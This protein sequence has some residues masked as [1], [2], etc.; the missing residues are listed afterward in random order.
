MIWPFVE[1]SW[2]AAVSLMA[3]TP[4]PDQSSTDGSKDTWVEMKK[5]QDMA[6]LFGKTLYHQ[7]DLSYYEAVNKE[8]LTR[9]YE[10]F[11]EEGKIT[12]TKSKEPNAPVRMQLS[13]E[14][15][16]ERDEQG[17]IKP[18]GKL[19]DFTEMMYVVRCASLNP[20]Q[21]MTLTERNQGERE[22]TGEIMLLYRPGY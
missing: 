14:W 13:Q 8:V 17:N 18:E 9:S 3:L 15:M 6:Q 10:R 1:A 19:W 16:P 4:P 21:L 5:A 20:P 11:V 7:G 2:L 12:L 22:R